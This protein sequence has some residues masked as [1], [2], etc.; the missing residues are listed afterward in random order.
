MSNSINTNIAAYYAQANITAASIAASSSVA[1][2]SSGNR[3]VQASDDVSA[4]ATGT[5]LLTTVSALKAAQTNAAQGTSLLQVADG[6]L[7]QI[8]TILQQQKS[9]ALQAGSGSLTDT[10]RGFLNQQF[11]ALASQIDSLTSSTTFNGVKLINGQLS[12]T[13]NVNSN[14]TN[15]T[16]SSM[17]V[18]FDPATV[19]VDTDTLILN[20]VT[21]TFA[22]APAA[23]GDVQTGGNNQQSLDN[24]YRTSTT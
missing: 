13:V 18:N 15:A 12:Q 11:Q 3:I 20:G 14:T 7:A 5:S 21:L 8:Q 19:I 23:A 16:K 17:S 9:I 1:R 22:D 4:L 2:L 24:L 10:D 6:A